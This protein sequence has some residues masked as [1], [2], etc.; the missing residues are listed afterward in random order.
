MK[1][2]SILFHYYLNYFFIIFIT[3]LLLQHIAIINVDD[4]IALFLHTET[5]QI[6]PFSRDD[7]ILNNC[8]IIHIVFGKSAFV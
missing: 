7:I 6:Y 3:A 8:S 5:L 4:S 1:I 2:G